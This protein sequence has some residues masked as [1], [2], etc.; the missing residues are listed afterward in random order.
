[1]ETMVA[2]M[3]A[4][5]VDRNFAAFQREL[6]DLLV[7]HPG[8]FALMHNGA[9]VDFFASMGDAARQGRTLFGETF[10]VQEVASKNESLGFYSYAVHNL[11]LI[12]I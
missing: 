7:S 8:K 4:T 12:H 9:V 1:M 10:S 2:T 11:S 6:P 3:E 5:E